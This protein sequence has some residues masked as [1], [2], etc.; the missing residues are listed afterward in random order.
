MKKLASVSLVVVAFTANS[1][2]EERMELEGARIYGNNEMPNV[3]Y[4]V[5][6]K[7]ET[8]DPLKV[9]PSTNLFDEALNPVDRDVFMREVEYYELLQGKKPAQ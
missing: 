7:D 8:L 5:P 6:W 9:Q 1:M 2:A 3:T 4:I